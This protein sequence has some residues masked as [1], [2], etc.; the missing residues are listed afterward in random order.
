MNRTFED[1]QTGISVSNYLIADDAFLDAHVVPKF[2]PQC[3]RS[4]AADEPETSYV[5]E[6]FIPEPEGFGS[7]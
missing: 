2:S 3:E 1:L 6:T 5:F 7:L 4:M